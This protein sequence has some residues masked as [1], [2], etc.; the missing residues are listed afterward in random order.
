MNALTINLLGNLPLTEPEI[1]A[2]VRDIIEGDWPTWKRERAVRKA[3]IG[4]PAQ[5]DALDAYLADIGAVVDQARADSALLHDTLGYERAVQM[6]AA[7]DL[8][9]EQAEMAQAI[10][11]A[12]SPEVLA[13]ATQRQPTAEPVEEPAEEPAP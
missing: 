8:E 9:P 5:A 4:E 13:L 3:R 10:I 12:A 7:G 1:Q 6:L 2:R 11:A